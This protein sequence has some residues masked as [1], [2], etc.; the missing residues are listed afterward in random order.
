MKED[1]KK[2]LVNK[3]VEFI[4]ALDETLS[5]KNKR[6]ISSGVYFVYR[7]KCN[8]EVK[9]TISTDSSE[10]EPLPGKKTEEKHTSK[11]S[12]VVKKKSS[13]KAK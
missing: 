2:E 3:A 6:S 5:L 9:T 7:D 13:H 8:N 11:T 12:K 4:E 1:Y 10:N